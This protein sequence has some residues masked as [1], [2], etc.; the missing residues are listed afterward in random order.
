[1]RTALDGMP[2][3][4]MNRPEGLVNVRINPENGKLANVSDPNAIFEVFRA[5]NAPQQSEETLQPE[6]LLTDPESESV[7]SQLF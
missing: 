1:M 2:E 7:P 6:I 4:I 3:A 5:E